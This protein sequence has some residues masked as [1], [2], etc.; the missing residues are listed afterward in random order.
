MKNSASSFNVIRP[1]EQPTE[2]GFLSSKKLL[3][4]VK[5]TSS[6]RGSFSIQLIA[7]A[8]HE[9]DNLWR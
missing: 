6:L 8:K 4:Q 3:P 2:Y 7:A 5:S 1:A 9:K